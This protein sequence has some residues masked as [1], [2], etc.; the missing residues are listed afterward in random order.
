[1]LVCNVVVDVDV[2]ALRE[3]GE[4]VVI[5]LDTQTVPASR[6]PCWPARIGER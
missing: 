3:H 2:D 1:V 6:A 5:V 4:E